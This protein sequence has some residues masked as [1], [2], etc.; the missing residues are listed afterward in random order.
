MQAT[1]T[2]SST[3]RRFTI[4]ATPDL[5][6]VQ[7]R[8]AGGEI[9][10]DLPDGVTEPHP[11]LQALAAILVLFPF[12]R[13][14][15]TLNVPI[16]WPLA[17]TCE[18]VLPFGVV[19][20]SSDGSVAARA[21]GDRPGLAFSG[22]VDS[23][24]A[25]ALMP[26][27]TAAVFLDRVAGEGQR[28]SRLYVKQSAHVACDMI[29]QRGYETLRI[30]S[31]LEHVRRPVGFPTDWA[32]GVPAVLLADDLGLASVS[33]GMVAESA[34]RVGH[35]LFTPLARRSI[36]TRWDALLRSVGLVLGA[37]VAGISEV[38]TTMIE[39]R[40]NLAG[41]GQSCIRGPKNQ[42]CLNCVK[43]LRKTLL[44][45]AIHERPVTAS[46]VDALLQAR[47]AEA[48]VLGTPI[49]HENVYRWLAS[50]LIVH[51]SSATWDAFKKRLDATGTVV[52]WCSRW[53]APSDLALPEHY[54]ASAVKSIASYLEPQTQTDRA[55]FEGWD[56]RT[57]LAGPEVGDAVT[58]LREQLERAKPDQQAPASEPRVRAA[59][60]TSVPDA[61]PTT[62]SGSRL[63]RRARALVRRVRGRAR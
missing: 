2:Y 44:D 4:D 43:C 50:R 42:P 37:P 13:T 51:G 27:D 23:T 61:A 24:A 22:G 18:S 62:P 9:F 46:E 12:V 48:V 35:D 54:R 34:Y 19:S 33:W 25:L 7:E 63:V 39:S 10:V 57:V 14:G 5:D 16:S 45:A 20:T 11:D 56:L 1:V 49:K 30:A 21:A 60:P 15:L 3:A 38:G 52:D 40:S 47:S 59:T 55:A 6:D 8:W 36:Y 41:V 32:N 53:Y 58:E 28:P 17:Q 31:N 26:L 29:S